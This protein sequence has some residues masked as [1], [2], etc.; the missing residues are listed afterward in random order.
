MEMVVF[1]LR[2]TRTAG[3]LC[4]R[5]E[6]RAPES[7]PGSAPCRR[8]FAVSPAPCGPWTGPWESDDGNFPRFGGNLTGWELEVCTCTWALKLEA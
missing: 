3:G 7:P 6:A 1:V 4:V 8:F 2:S 5:I